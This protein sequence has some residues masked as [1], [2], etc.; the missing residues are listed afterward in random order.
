MLAEDHGFGARNH[1]Q[2]MA[3][4]FGALVFL[5]RAVEVRPGHAVEFH[6]MVAEPG[7]CLR[8]IAAGIVNFDAIAGGKRDGLQQGRLSGNRIEKSKH[9]LF[10][11]I[12][13]VAH[14]ERCG[15]K[16]GAERADVKVSVACSAEFH[17]SFPSAFLLAARA[18]S[19]S[20]TVWA[21]ETN[22]ASNCDGAMY[23]PLSIVAWK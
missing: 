4:G 18:M 5:E 19:M 2:Q 11:K 21:D 20:P 8:V 13:R 10:V 6:Q 14:P 22:I 15:L 1:M 23:T 7:G 16:V 12:Q 17:A 9:A 3:H